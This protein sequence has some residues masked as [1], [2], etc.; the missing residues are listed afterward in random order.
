[1][2]AIK[3]YLIEKQQKENERLDREYQRIQKRKKEKNFIKNN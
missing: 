3:D 2:G 1:M